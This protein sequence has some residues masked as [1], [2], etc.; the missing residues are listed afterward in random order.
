[1]IMIAEQE[2]FNLINTTEIEKILENCGK[3]KKIFCFGAGTAGLGLLKSLPSKYNIDCFLDNNPNLYNEKIN[4]IPICSPDI[5]K[6]SKNFI[7]LVNSQFR[8]AICQQLDTYGLKENKDYF[9]IF[10]LF[11]AWWRI[12]KFRKTT[13]QFCDFINEIPDNIFDNIKVKED[14]PK[15]GIVCMGV[16]HRCT[17]WRDITTFLLLLFNGYKVSL[18]IDDLSNILEC[19]IKEHR[20][21]I[22]SFLDDVLSLLT[23][24]F[25]NLEIIFYNKNDKEPLDNDDK[26]EIEKLVNINIKYFNALVYYQFDNTNMERTKAFQN[27]LTENMAILMAFFK[28]HKFDVIHLCGGVAEHQGIYSWIGKKLNFRVS[29][30]D[31]TSNFGSIVSTDRP[32][33]HCMDI[34]KLL[35][36]NCFNS[37]EKEQIVKMA[38]QNFNKRENVINNPDEYSFQIVNQKGNQK[39][40]FDFLIPL[41]LNCDAAALGLDVVFSSIEEWL[42]ETI[43]FILEHTTSNIIIREHPVQCFLEEAVVD[44]DYYP[45]IKKFMD[46]DR[47]IYIKAADTVNTYDILSSVKTVLPFSSTVG[48][49]AA[50]MNKFV[51]THTSCYYSQ[52]SF[53]RKA[54]NKQQYFDF[55]LTSLDEANPLNT[56]QQEEAYLYYYCLMNIGIKTNLTEIDNSWMKKTI[57]ELSQEKEIQKLLN[58]IALEQPTSFLNIKEQLL[59]KDKIC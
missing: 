41:N 51:I 40:K 25:N 59:E 58:I 7:V 49:E 55:I 48:I 3:D 8:R 53:I 10:D 52:S 56:K 42:E 14:S 54:E 26:T 44:K 27:I 31:G 12:E 24:K 4:E 23:K 50:L 34:P 45:E 57:K 11:D 16:L 20:K 9:V 36:K 29:T 22:K 39:Y 2:Y 21:F 13:K 5:L 32:C 43:S 6:T 18:L 17:P 35:K 33:A 38:K 15:I 19:Y 37:F 47:C 28:S 46:S 30:Y 1:M